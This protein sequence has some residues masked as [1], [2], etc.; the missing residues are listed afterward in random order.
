MSA[1]TP[2]ALIK[3]RLSTPR[4]IKI[5]V[6]PGVH[7]S[8]VGRQVNEG[9][10]EGEGQHV[11]PL[12]D[13]RLGARRRGSSTLAR[14]SDWSRDVDRVPGPRVIRRWVRL[15]TWS[16]VVAPAS[17][18]FT[19][20]ERLG[21][22][23]KVPDDRE[24]ADRLVA[25][26]IEPTASVATPAVSSISTRVSVTATSASSPSRCSLG[27]VTA[28]VPDPEHHGPEREQDH[29]DDWYSPG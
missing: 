5:Q 17:S 20:V 1:V 11:G 2:W 27:L 16:P 28:G 10:A 8:G 24:R 22:T 4:P 15:G 21:S 14:G 19:A 3:I 29:R 6:L 23:V 25:V 26:A 7:R 9:H 12:D 18:P 13:Q